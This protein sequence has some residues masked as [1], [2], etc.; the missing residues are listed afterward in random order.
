MRPSKN[1]FSLIELLAVV[2]IML[3]LAGL[4][5]PIMVH[6][7]ARAKRAQAVAQ[8]TAMENALENFK[9][10]MGYY[11][12]TLTE[13]EYF[14]DTV[15]DKS[16]RKQIIEALSGFDKNKNKLSVYWN[17][18]DWNGPYYEFKTKNLDSSGQLLDP[19]KQP[20][21]FDSTST[22]RILEN[23]GFIDI[24]SK[25]P[26][27]DWDSSN[28]NSSKNDDNICNWLGDFAKD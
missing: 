11:P 4:G 3:I 6:Q 15:T 27:K 28:N 23:T 2:A 17:D 20:Y 19:W 16:K 26:D 21:L 25:G 8:I 22:G 1:A 14:G 24:L 13:G 9:N 10:D 18:D 7:Y 5:I 12:V